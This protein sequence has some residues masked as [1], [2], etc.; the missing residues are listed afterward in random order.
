MF[1][2]S[3][4]IQK[5]KDALDSALLIKERYKKHADSM[6]Q[7]LNDPDYLTFWKDKKINFKKEVYGYLADNRDKIKVKVAGYLETRSYKD[8]ELMRLNPSMIKEPT[9]QAIYK[10]QKLDFAEELWK[11]SDHLYI[12]FNKPEIKE[13]K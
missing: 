8:L 4:E 6:R 2:K 9:Y 13:P 10:K 3:D 7:L 11:F 1:G 12:F 5:L